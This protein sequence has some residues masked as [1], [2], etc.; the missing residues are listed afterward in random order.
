MYITNLLNNS[1]FHSILVE[2]N[3]L[4]TLYT[5]FLNA[6]L[7]LLTVVRTSVANDGCTALYCAC[8]YR[9]RIRYLYFVLHVLLGSKFDSR[10]DCIVILCA[11]V[12]VVY[13][14]KIHAYR[15]RGPAPSLEGCG[16]RDYPFT[17]VKGLAR[18]TS[19]QHGRT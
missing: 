13:T 14:I 5:T 19:I 8:A 9:Y 7:A 4:L 12:G 17:L 15:S 2:N 6:I 11:R 16:A 18:E 1:M 10:L 3:S